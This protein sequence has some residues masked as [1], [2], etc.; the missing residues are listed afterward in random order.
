VE[1]AKEWIIDVPKNSLNK[2][3][4]F[5]FKGYVVGSVVDQ[6]PVPKYARL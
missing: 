3:P 4:T 6:A 1:E 2:T 5:N